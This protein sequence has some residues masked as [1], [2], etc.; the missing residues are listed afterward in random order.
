MGLDEGLV[1]Y[2]AERAEPINLE[3]AQNHPRNRYFEEIG[4]EPYHEFLGV[5]IIHHRKTL[6]VLVV[7]QKETR[8]FDESEEA[9]LITLSAQLAGVNA[10]AEATGSLSLRGDVEDRPS[11]RFNGMQGAPGVAIGTAVISFLEA[12]LENVPDKEMEEFDLEVQLFQQAV[13]ETTKDISGISEKLEDRLQ[14]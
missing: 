3:D 1:G 10:H 8:R 7:Q 5:P 2:V 9:L 11:S 13:A 4:E 6:G 14:P 12:D